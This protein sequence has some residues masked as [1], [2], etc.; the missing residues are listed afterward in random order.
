[1]IIYKI[2]NK[3]NGKVYIGQTIHTLE[4]R[5]R[6]HINRA[7]RGDMGH[8]YPA[9]R[10]YGINNFECE[11]IETIDKTLPNALDLLNEREIYWI[12]YYDSTNNKCGYNITLGGDINRMYSPVAKQHHAEKLRSLET[13]QNISAGRKKY[14]KE[15]GFSDK[16]RNNLSKNAKNQVWIVNPETKHR[17]HVAKNKLEEFFSKGYILSKNYFNSENIKN[18]DY[19]AMKTKTACYCIVNNS[20][21]Y[22]FKNYRLA[23]RWW[24]ENYKPFGEGV[25]SECTFQRKI[26]ASIAGNNPIIYKKG[27]IKYIIDNIVWYSGNYYKGGDFNC[28]KSEN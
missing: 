21:I 28:E 24:Y 25:Y 20:E 27:K 13:R 5:Y 14:I 19:A 17:T 8:L 2:T 10:K 7:N 4:E 26:K 12:K 11:V 9:M 18:L 3:I 22:N 15:H 6:G 1:M 16:H 23:G